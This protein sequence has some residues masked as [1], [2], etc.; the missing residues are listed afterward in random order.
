MVVGDDDIDAQFG[1]PPYDFGS[2]NAGIHANDEPDTFGGS[3]LDY[4]RAHAV[5]IAQTV[6]HEERCNAAGHFDGFFQDDDGGG[7]IHIVIAVD[8]DALT[9]GD[10]AAQPLDGRGH[11]AQFAGGMQVIERRAQKAA[12]GMGVGQVAGA[13]NARGGQADA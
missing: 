9:G 10:S 5:A 12:G 4:F 6:G 3:L 2:A 7:A 1:G 8:E 11:A 13:E